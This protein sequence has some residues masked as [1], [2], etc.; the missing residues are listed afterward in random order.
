[1]TAQST[2]P[3]EISVRIDGRVFLDDC[4]SEKLCRALVHDAADGRDTAVLDARQCLD[5]GLA[6]SPKTD[7]AYSNV[8]HEEILRQVA[9]LEGKRLPLA[10]P[11]VETKALS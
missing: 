1:M 2:S 5:M 10:T 11:T 7:D 8:F 4:L 9:G 6:H 3:E